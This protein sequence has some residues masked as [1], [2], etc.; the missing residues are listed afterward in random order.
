M[1]N[2]ITTENLDVDYVRVWQDDN[3]STVTTSQTVPLT[4]DPTPTPFDA[5]VTLAKFMSMTDADVAAAQSQ[6]LDTGRLT[7]SLEI[8]TPKII[9]NGLTLD[10]VS[11]LNN[12]ISFQSDT[13]FFGRPYF[14]SDTAGFALIKQGDKSVDVTFGKDYL[15]PPIVNAGIA[16]ADD[17]ALKGQTDQAK[18]DAARAAQDQLAQALFDSGTQYIVTHTNTHGFTIILNKP[19]PQ[20]ITFSWTALAV[21]NVKTFAS[22]SQSSNDAGAGVGQI[23]TGAGGQIATPLDLTGA[24]VIS[25]DQSSSSQTSSDNSSTNPTPD[26]TTSPS[27]SPAGAAAPSSPVDASGTIP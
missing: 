24:T 12:A 4:P 1:T 3:N 2:T 15:D 13:I 21:K 17:P 22:K 9:A 11:A 7:A 6:Q 25:P 8:V 5:K 20:D 27:A 14:N 26:S 18:I 19:A 16:L 23:I 10:N